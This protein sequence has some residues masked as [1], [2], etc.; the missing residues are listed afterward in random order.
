MTGVFGPESY[1]HSCGVNCDNGWT[2]GPCVRDRGPAVPLFG[3]K[4]WQEEDRMSLQ[5]NFYKVAFSTEDYILRNKVNL[6]CFSTVAG[7]TTSDPGPAAEAA[8]K[9]LCNLTSDDIH[10]A[11]V[12]SCLGSNSSIYSRMLGTRYATINQSTLKEGCTINYNLSDI[13]DNLPLGFTSTNIKVEVFAKD[14]NNVYDSRI[15][16]H[17]QT[18]GQFLLYPDQFPATMDISMDVGTP[19]GL[20]TLSRKVPLTCQ[21]NDSTNVIMDIE[22]KTSSKGFG[23]TQS[24]FNSLIENAYCNIRNMVDSLRT[25]S[26]SGCPDMK[27]SSK[28][29]R[30]V[31]ANHDGHI[32]TVYDRLNHIGKEKIMGTYCDNDCEERT[33]E[34]TLQEW[35]TSKDSTDCN[36]AERILRLESKIAE[37]EQRILICCE[38]KTAAGIAAQGSNLNATNNGSLSGQSSNL[39]SSNNSSNGS[40]SG[41]SNQESSSPNGEGGT[42]GGGTS[43][44]GGGTTNPDDRTGNTNNGPTSSGQGGNSDG[45]SGGTSGGGTDGSQNPSNQ[46]GGDGSMVVIVNH[47]P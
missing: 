43:G 46:N 40:N 44:N 47:T 13:V 17:K 27:H 18:V 37:L 29:I 26:V 9:K 28:D 42:N 24:E 19:G 22:D 5:E 1:C 45:T 21:N 23:I 6:G 15:A 11:N 31:V 30:D 38:M 35:A 8:L 10:I 12:L 14:P 2:F 36:H 34:T 3:I 32:C 16:T 33:F 20:V 25:V 7:G 41:G 4:E 39:G